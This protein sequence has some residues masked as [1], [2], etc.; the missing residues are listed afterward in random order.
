V[1]SLRQE[2]SSIQIRQIEVPSA[3]RALFVQAAW[4]VLVGIKD[5]DRYGKD[6]VRLA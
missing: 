4:V 1:P 5:W 3:L 6:I 2:P